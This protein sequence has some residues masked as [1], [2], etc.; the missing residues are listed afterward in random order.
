M[1]V[2]GDKIKPDE[3]EKGDADARQLEL[4]YFDEHAGLPLEQAVE[5]FRRCSG[6]RR[7]LAEEARRLKPTS[8]N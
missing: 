2:G 7:K 6:D 3:H 8:L 1:A 5:L 4:E